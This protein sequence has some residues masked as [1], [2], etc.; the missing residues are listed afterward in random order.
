MR[1]F[2][3]K[4]DISCEF[5]VEACS[6]E[7]ICAITLVTVLITLHITFSLGLFSKS[8]SFVC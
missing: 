5:A 4:L 2:H 3:P 7:L 1:L 8:Y 6:Q